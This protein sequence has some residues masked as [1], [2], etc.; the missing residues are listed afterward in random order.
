VVV[1]VEPQHHERAIEGGQ[2]REV[3]QH[4]LQRE[5][6]P[7]AI[8]R[9]R[10]VIGERLGGVAALAPVA[11][12][13]SVDRDRRDSAGCMVTTDDSRLPAAPSH[14]ARGNVHASEITRRFDI[15][16]R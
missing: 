13:R 4:R 7:I 11:R 14:A 16:R 15:A 6:R 9:R 8:D 5:R 12:D 1:V 3:A 2:L 10:E